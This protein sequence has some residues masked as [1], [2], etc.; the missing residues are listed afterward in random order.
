LA[1][2]LGRFAFTRIAQLLLIEHGCFFAVGV[3][4]WAVLMKQ[5]TRNRIFWIAVFTLAGVIQIMG[6]GLRLAMQDLFVPAAIWLSSL[7][8]LVFSVRR[9]DGFASLG[10]GF[11]SWTRKLGLATYPLYLIHFPLAVWLAGYLHSCGVPWAVALPTTVLATVALALAITLYPER[12]L[13][14]A[15]RRLSSFIGPFWKRVQQPA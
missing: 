14:T 7:V 2:V 5:A 6:E 9:N 13:R 15:L 1:L 10:R 4:L 3:L 12:M 11:A 8:L